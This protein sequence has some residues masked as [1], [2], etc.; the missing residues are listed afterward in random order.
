VLHARTDY[1]RIQDPAGLIPAD[2]PVFLIRGKDLV[3]PATV[4][5]WANLAAM[6]GAEPEI[7]E[8]ARRQARRMTEWQQRSGC[9]VPD[10]PVGAGRKG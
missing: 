7:V 3:G 8:L 4:E 2:E 9:Q 10:M 5:A 1:D 6:A